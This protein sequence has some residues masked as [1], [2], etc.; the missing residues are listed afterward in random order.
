MHEEEEFPSR[1]HETTL[2]QLYN[3]KGPMQQLSSHRF[4]HMKEWKARL[5]EALEVEGM[6]DDILESG[7]KFQL[8]GKPHMR[9]QFH[10][11]VLKSLLALKA[12]NKER[13]I[14]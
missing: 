6:K 5:A 11:F 13:A 14:V 10:L 2:V 7:T 3:Q 12:K 1:F 4:L 9:V 8:G